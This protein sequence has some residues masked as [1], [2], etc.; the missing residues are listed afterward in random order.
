MSK[1]YREVR[2]TDKGI[3]LLTEPY[4]IWVVP[5]EVDDIPEHRELK[6]KFQRWA[7]YTDEWH[8]AS[9]PP[10]P[11]DFLPY[12]VI[13]VLGVDGCPFVVKN[14]Q[15]DWTKTGAQWKRISPPA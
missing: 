2:D 7:S 11:E 14:W 3:E 10:K 6:E 8:P 12:N 15:P 9:E 5:V 13:L 4:P 1:Y